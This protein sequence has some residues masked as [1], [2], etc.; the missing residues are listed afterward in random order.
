MI[1]KSFKSVSNQECS[2]YIDDSLNFEGLKYFDLDRYDR[3]VV[4]FD[5]HLPDHLIDIIFKKLRDHNEDL[6]KI[7]LAAEEQ[8]KSIKQSISIVEKL[9]KNT[10]GRHDL[11]ISLGGG[12]ISDLASFVSSIYMRGIPYIAIPTT[13][14]GQVDAVTAGKTCVNGPQTKNLLGTF[15]FPSIVYN[16]ISFFKSLPVREMRQGWSEIF[17]YALLGSK[18]LLKLME[19]YFSSESPEVLMKIIEETIR[20][21]LKIRQVDPLSSNLGHTFG[22]AFEKISNYKVSHGDAI[23]IGTLLAIAFGEKMKVT[24]DG[25]HQELLELMERFSLNTKFSSEFDAHSVASMMLKDKKSS[26]KQINLVLLKDL[27]KPYYGKSSPFYSVDEKTMKDFIENYY[28]NNL[29]R[30][31]ENLYSSLSQ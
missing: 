17:K 5:K 22:H 27:S 13:L 19:E 31:D 29:E 14:I 11:I 12:F 30:L 1:K 28:S 15:Y 7:P 8:N 16:N 2:F 10:I 4:I 26:S 6:L 9:E 3:F 18:K 20:V 25:L 21:R 23:S 24:R